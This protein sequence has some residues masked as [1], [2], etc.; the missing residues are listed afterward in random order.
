MGDKLQTFLLDA[1]AHT[2]EQLTDEETGLGNA[3]MW[4]SPSLGDRIFFATI[5]DPEDNAVGIAVF[6]WIDGAWR[7]IKTI[8]PPVDFPYIGSPEYFVFRG[9][10]Y[11][12]YSACVEPLRSLTGHCG[13]AQIWLS[14]AEPD[15]EVHRRISG[16]E[17]MNRNDPEAYVSSEG[18][19]IFY[20]AAPAGGLRRCATGL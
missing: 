12:F 6:R 20:H 16:D 19:W 15:N 13:D 17:P 8:E 11:V 2:L 18:A 1:D 7:I 9:Q 14:G 4:T 10:S 3:W 5:L